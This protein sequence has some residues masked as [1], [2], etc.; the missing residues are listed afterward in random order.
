MNKIMKRRKFIKT[1][2]ISNLGLLSIPTVLTG[3]GWKGANDRVNVAVIGI[4]GMGQTHIQ[5]Y[6]KVKNV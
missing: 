3:N 2:S 6:Q 1:A 5:S 4:H